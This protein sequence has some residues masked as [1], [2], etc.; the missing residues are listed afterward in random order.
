M[1]GSSVMFLRFGRAMTT[2]VQLAWWVALANVC[3]ALAV[4]KG[5][6]WRG[7][8]LGGLAIGLALMSKGP[9]ALAQ[10]VLPLAAFV[11]WRRWRNPASARARRVGWAPVVAAVVAALAVALP[12]PLWVVLR[13]SGQ[14]EF[15]FR[16][17][18]QGGRAD[19]GWDPPWVYLAILPLLLPWAGFVV[20]GLVRVVRERSE[21][22]V[23]A[24][25]LLLLPIAVMC[26]VNQKND[27]YLLPMLAPA[28]AIGAME[29][30]R[31]GEGAQRAYRW[32]VVGTWGALLLI[33]VGVPVA[34]ATVLERA[35]GGR[36]WS[37][38]VAAAS[39]GVGVAVIA[40]G[41]FL[42]GEA[43]VRGL[44]PAGVVLMLWTHG[45]LMHGYATSA[46]GLSDGRPVADAIVAALPPDT[47]V[48]CYQAPGRFSRVP[49]DTTIYL[50]RT[51]RQAIDPTTLPT[52]AG[53]NRVMLVHRRRDEPVPAGMRDWK[54]I[55]TTQKNAGTW[56]VR[57]SPPK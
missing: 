50:N 43:R 34:G 8:V 11:A 41:W 24:A 56:E 32:V 31:G 6:R 16:E 47:E 17:V 53:G 37:A 57:L 49:V 9:V 54:V 39:A 19:Y 46:R 55:G 51:V 1:T 42:G 52:T 28:A 26:C 40:V 12:W 38:G 3:F 13:R 44:I 5:W 15:W 48:W 18:A 25:A 36:W 20:L 14:I 30:V 22:G 27:R 10:T 29:F 45:L 2:D 7:C 35:D 4:L 23:L 33:A 21:E